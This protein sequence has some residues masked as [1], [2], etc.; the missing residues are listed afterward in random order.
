MVLGALFA[1]GWIPTLQNVC[2][3]EGGLKLPSKTL[4]VL[5]KGLCKEEGD[6]QGMRNKF[7]EVVK[8]FLLYCERLREVDSVNGRNLEV[9]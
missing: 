4:E 2:D 9:N 3:E 1:W 5:G 8:P 7:F 6:G